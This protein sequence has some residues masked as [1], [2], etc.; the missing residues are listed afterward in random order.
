MDADHVTVWSNGG[1][2]DINNCEILCKSHNMAN[3]NALTIKEEASSSL[4]T[5]TR[6]FRNSQN[7]LDWD[8]L[9]GYYWIMLV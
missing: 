3:A 5:Q 6:G 2:T 7:R 8:A 4:S 9:L 1:N